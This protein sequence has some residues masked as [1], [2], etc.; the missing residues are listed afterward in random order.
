MSSVTCSVIHFPDIRVIACSLH[1]CTPPPSPS[2]DLTSVALTCVTFYTV[3]NSLRF[4][5]PTTG[6]VNL[7]R[8]HTTPQKYLFILRIYPCPFSSLLCHFFFPSTPATPWPWSQVTWRSTEPRVPS[9]DLCA[10]CSYFYCHHFV[11]FIL[12]YN[13]HIIKFTLLKKLCSAVVFIIIAD[14][15]NHCLLPEHFITPRKT[16]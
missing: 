13:L 7:Y 9:H 10:H 3:L 6:K 16:P 1:V 15:Y 14:L 12:I 2:L 4:L 5:L 8:T 11:N